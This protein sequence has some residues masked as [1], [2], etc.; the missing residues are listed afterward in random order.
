MLGLLTDYGDFDE[1]LSIRSNPLV[2]PENEV[3]ERAFSGRYCLLSVKMNYHVEL[4]PNETV[5]KGIIEDG[6]FWDELVRRYW[7]SKTT[8]GF[9]LGMCFPSRCDNDD[10]E[11]ILNQG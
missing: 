7:T 11:Q 6:I 8:K 1:C 3:E 2:E 10:L 5:P 4:Q 9:Q